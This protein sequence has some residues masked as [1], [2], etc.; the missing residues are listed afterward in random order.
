M[1]TPVL[2]VKYILSL[3]L[4]LDI[5]RKDNKRRFASPKS[6]FQPSGNAAPP[7]ASGYSVVV[8]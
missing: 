4:D 5:V 3:S 6:S 7:E 1:W 2:L 8:L